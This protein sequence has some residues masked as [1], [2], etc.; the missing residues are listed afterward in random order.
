MKIANIEDIYKTLQWCI[1][2]PKEIVGRRNICV[3]DLVGTE[4]CERLDGDDSL[5]KLWRNE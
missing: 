2:Q 3:S 4:L 1:A 5:F